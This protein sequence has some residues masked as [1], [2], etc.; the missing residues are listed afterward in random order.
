MIKGHLNFCY[1][2]Q[3]MIIPHAMLQINVLYCGSLSILLESLKGKQRPV[4]LA[5]HLQSNDAAK[6]NF[7]AKHEQRNK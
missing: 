3:L 1:D 6:V 5:L 7:G 4:I 2:L